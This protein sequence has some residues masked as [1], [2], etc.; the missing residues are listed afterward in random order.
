MLINLLNKNKKTKKMF[1][2]L[3]ITIMIFAISACTSIKVVN[4]NDVEE[5]KKFNLVYSLP[6][7]VLKIEVELIKSVRK[8][9]P[10]SDYAEKYLGIKN[11]IKS[12]ESVWKISD[13]NIYEDYMPDTANTFIM[14][15][16]R[17]VNKINLTNNGVLLSIN[18]KTSYKQKNT[19]TE[20]Y[21]G[22]NEESP[23][24][25][26]LS[27]KRNFEEVTD[28][29]YKIIRTDSTVRK[30]PVYS[31]H[32]EKKSTEQKAEEAA[33]FII[34]IRKRRLRIL[35]G[36]DEIIPEGEAA[37]HIIEEL[38]NIEQRYLQLF[39]GIEK[40]YTVKRIF[41]F[42]PENKKAKPY[43]LFKMS[44]KQG[45]I[46]KNSKS[47][48]AYYISVIPGNHTDIIKKMQQSGTQ[49]YYKGLI[50][51]IPEA[52]KVTIFEERKKIAEKN[53]V[54]IS[55]FG[56]LNLI[57]ANIIKQKNVEI[58]FFHKTGAL[59]SISKTK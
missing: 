13:I 19:T 14:N 46:N 54:M 48:T 47:G 34:K 35:T 18:G 6:K 42:V 45:I 28:T 36:K 25:Y 40:K 11:V 9:G 23:E 43:L 2:R 50:Y 17:S 24:F 30:I 26:D 16:A 22:T 52:S 29:N 58:N 10:Y 38:N 31:H 56:A 33:N 1:Y 7:T 32:L 59:K 20:I 15:R 21:T 39:V 44:T 3:G 37:K 8:K 53:N 12:D 4:I 49:K 57:P 55:Q 5:Q 27:V 51:R 41:D